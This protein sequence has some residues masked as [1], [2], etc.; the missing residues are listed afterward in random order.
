[1]HTVARYYQKV[2]SG[3]SENPFLGMQN[4]LHQNIDS[5]GSLESL[6]NRHF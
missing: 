5:G 4:D 3:A 1:M 2:S 6:A